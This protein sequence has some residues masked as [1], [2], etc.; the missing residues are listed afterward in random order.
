MGLTADKTD[1]GWTHRI[2]RDPVGWR[3]HVLVGGPHTYVSNI[4][5]YVH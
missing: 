3:K 4:R 5:T 1:R 2:E